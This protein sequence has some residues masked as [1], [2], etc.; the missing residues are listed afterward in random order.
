MAPDLQLDLGE[1]SLAAMGAH[2]L[3]VNCANLKPEESLL[4]IYEDPSLG[5]Y[6]EA[7]LDAITSG[8]KALGVEPTILPVGAPTNDRDPA[9]MEMV[10]RHDCTVFLTR[11]GDQDRFDDPVPG[12]RTVM[13]YARTI[14]ML[15]SPY[16]A[17]NHQAFVALKGAI[18]T[19]L[20]SAARIE[21]TCPLGTNLTGTP[22]KLNLHDLD[23]GGDVSVQR[24][25]LGVPMPMGAKTFDGQIAL[26]RYLAPTG[27]KVYEPA[28]APIG[29][30]VLAEIKEGRLITLHGN[31]E[32]RKSVAA[33]HMN[34]AG[35]F[36]L[37]ANAIHS[38]HAGMHPG[39]AYLAPASDDPDRWANCIFTNPRVL[40]FHTCGTVP[41]G[42]ICWMIF[43]H[44]LLVDGKALWSHGRLNVEEFPET[45][46][47]LDQWP[48]LMPLF[49]D[50]AMQIG[51][52]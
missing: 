14:D 46:T 28:F 19:I 26:S 3:L 16:G 20:F 37:D 36:G 8:A 10:D 42:E 47:C 22:Q 11:I 45:Q 49:R 48:E 27:S 13:V 1:G 40:H 32:D 25:P 44:T 17:A 5:W 31:E 29:E 51:L 12:R 9:I 50:P 38:F 18:N 6:D 7:V 4:I 39:C 33:H 43:D 35:Q 2:N 30:T 24:F 15:A 21:L 41:P 23:N 34:I 52:D